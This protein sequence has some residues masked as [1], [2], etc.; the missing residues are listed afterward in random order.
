V[1][2]QKLGTAENVTTFT[3]EPM[4]ATQRMRLSRLR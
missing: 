3:V 1:V 2:S 4:A